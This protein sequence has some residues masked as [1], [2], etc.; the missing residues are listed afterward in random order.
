[1]ATPAS[2]PPVPT[3]QMKP[4]ILPSVSSQISGPV[5]SNMALPIGDIVELI[6][7]DRALRMLL[8]EPFG[9]TAGKFHVI[10]GIGIGHG[11]HFD[12]ARALQAQHVLFL[13]AL[14]VG[15]DDHGFIAERIG[16]QGEADAG[17]A[18]GAFDDEAAGLQA[19]RAG[20]HR[21]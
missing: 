4:S 5:V 9:Q 7:P 16:D 3:A 17:I 14:R 6:G 2:V 21:R 20:R 11:R 15:N 18:G 8:G 1:M 13:L 12:Q 19:C 10:I